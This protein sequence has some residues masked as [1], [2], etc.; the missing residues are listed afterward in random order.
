MRLIIR[1]VLAALLALSVAGCAGSSKSQKAD[2]RASAGSEM[3]GQASDNPYVESYV[4]KGRPATTLPPDPAGPKIYRGE[5]QVADY[6]RMLENGYDM[7]GYSSFKAG[8]VSPD[9]ASAQAKQIKADLVLLYAEVKASEPASVRIQKMREQA[10]NKDGEPV[11]PDQKLYEYFASYWVKI[12]PPLLGVHVSGP[13][14]GEKTNGLTV[15]AVVKE[16]PAAKA[17]IEEGDMI[18]RIGDVDVT[19]PELLSQAAQRY[20]GQTVELLVQ[21]GGIL[22]KKMVTLNSRQ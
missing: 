3:A 1:L 5:D 22:D 9:L 4:D 15:I 21:R 2:D 13:A 18:L 8:D 12:A 7:L 10:K 17:E 19:K 11:A 6:Q 14:L 20:Q 16:S